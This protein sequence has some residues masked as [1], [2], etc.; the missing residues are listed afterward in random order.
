MIPYH[1]QCVPDNACREEA[2][3]TETAAGAA[4]ESSEELSEEEEEE[5]EEL[6]PPALDLSMV[7]PEDS[8][9]PQPMGSRTDSVRVATRDWPQHHPPPSSSLFP[10]F[11]LRGP[12]GGQVTH[13]RHRFRCLRPTPIGH[14]PCFPRGAKP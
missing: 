1:L 11:Y 2:P 3:A 10:P 14:G 12:G 7:V 4:N 5:E 13:R 8:G 9:P 6:P